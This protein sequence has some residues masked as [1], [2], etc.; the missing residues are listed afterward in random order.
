MFTETPLLEA[1][2]MASSVGFCVCVA[3][4]TDGVERKNKT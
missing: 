1:N 2:K 3:D 4:V